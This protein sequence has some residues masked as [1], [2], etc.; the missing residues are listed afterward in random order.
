MARVRLSEEQWSAIAKAG[1]LP[2]RARKRIEGVLTNYRVLQQASA[3]RSRPA[4]TRKELLHIA[5]LVEKLIMVVKGVNSDAFAALIPPTSRLA[6]D[7]DDWAAI[8]SAARRDPEKI[9]HARLI[10]LLNIRTPTTRDGLQL[11][12]ERVLTVEQLR[13]WFENAARS[14]PAE[15]RGEHKAAENHQ[16]LVRQLEGTSKNCRSWQSETSLG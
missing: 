1:K 4:Q 14:L 2:K 15:A 7:A 8:V 9:D 11:L 6:T 16:W 13:L 12:Y 3:T 10:K 5:E